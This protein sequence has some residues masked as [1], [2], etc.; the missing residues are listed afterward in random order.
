M[1]QSVT[2]LARLRPEAS[3]STQIPEMVK[4]L[5]VLSAIFTGLLLLMAIHKPAL[6]QEAEDSPDPVYVSYV[7]QDLSDPARARRLLVRI[8][9]AA[10][11]ACGAMDGLSIPTQELI[12]RSDCHHETFNRTVAAFHSP[13]LTH[14]AGAIDPWIGP[15]TQEP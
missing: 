14:L 5:G 2:D 7:R 10:L 8:D 12:I 13:A 6:A 15:T 11:K 3:I 1:L 9:R 4:A